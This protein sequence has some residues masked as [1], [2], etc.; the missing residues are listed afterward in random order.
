MTLR[1]DNSMDTADTDKFPNIMQRLNVLVPTSTSHMQK[2]NWQ[3][4]RHNLES[5]DHEQAGND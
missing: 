3:H 1:M 4:I 5:L 2:P